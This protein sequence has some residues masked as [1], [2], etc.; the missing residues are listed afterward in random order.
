MLFHCAL[1][2]CH[3]LLIYSLVYESMPLALVVFLLQKSTPRRRD[4]A[5]LMGRHGFM[6]VRCLLFY[7][8]G[9]MAGEP[10]IKTAKAKY[11]FELH[12]VVKLYVA[13]GISFYG[14]IG[15]MPLQC[16]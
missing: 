8:G 14:D 7:G 12:Y 11:V 4:K 9:V 6:T 5:C 10:G 3:C 13:G 15:R 16:R 2:I 1:F